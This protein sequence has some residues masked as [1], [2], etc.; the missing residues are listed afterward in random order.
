MNSADCWQCPGCG[1]TIYSLQVHQCGA[2][3]ISWPTAS[4][5][6]GDGSAS[7]FIQNPVL[8][9]IEDK[10]DK[11]IEDII[12]LRTEIFWIERWTSRRHEAAQKKKPRKKKK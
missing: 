9:R 8:Q 1:A 4:G 11:L 7:I 5:G 2:D 6:S 10:L 12:E 3:P